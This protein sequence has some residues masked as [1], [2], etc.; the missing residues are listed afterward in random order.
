MTE[1]HSKKCMERTAR[2]EVDSCKLNHVDRFV[3]G[4]WVCDEKQAGR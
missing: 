3:V 4:C 1:I 2:D